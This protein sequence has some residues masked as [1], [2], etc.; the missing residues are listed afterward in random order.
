MTVIDCRECDSPYCDGCNI[1][2]LACALGHNE[3]EF[4]EKHSV[5]IPEKPKTGKWIPDDE[6]DPHLIVPV[7]CSVCHSRAHFEDW[8]RRFVLSEY[9]PHCGARMEGVE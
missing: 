1:Y 9:C 8:N 6:D 3:F 5:I 7:R 4:D 2:A